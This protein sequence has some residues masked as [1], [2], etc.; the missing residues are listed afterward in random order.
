MDTG[1]YIEQTM[2]WKG[3]GVVE[4]S[5]R[6]KAERL[7]VDP[8]KIACWERKGPCSCTS[9]KIW[10][11]SLCGLIL[12]SCSPAPMTAYKLPAHPGSPSTP[13]ISFLSQ[14]PHETACSVAHRLVC[15]AEIVIQDS[16]LDFQL[17]GLP[18][19]QPRLCLSDVLMRGGAIRDTGGLNPGLQRSRTRREDPPCSTLLRET[20]ARQRCDGLCLELALWQ[21]RVSR[22]QDHGVCLG[23]AVVRRGQHALL[24]P[25]EFPL[26]RTAA[27]HL[28]GVC[29]HM[30]A[31]LCTYGHVCECPISSHSLP[32]INLGT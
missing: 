20:Q 8:K 25:E 15:W 30:R 19:H 11:Q 21:G 13:S 14:G 5:S 17:E 2:S 12:N 1:E 18:S 26:S 7:N 16:F 27:G 22:G 9:D 28:Q 6:S 31:G 23:G 4:I 29:A 24:S 3:E 10:K 32:M